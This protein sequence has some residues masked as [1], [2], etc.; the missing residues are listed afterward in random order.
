MVESVKYAASETTVGQL[1]V[2]SS[3][4]TFVFTSVAIQCTF[5]VLKHFKMPNLLKRKAEKKD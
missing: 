5:D 3:V 4:C 2:M 1:A